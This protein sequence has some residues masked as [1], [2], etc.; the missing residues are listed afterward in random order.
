MLNKT[1]PTNIPTLS[2][3][4]CLDN[5]WKTLSECLVALEQSK[6]EYAVLVLQPTVEAFFLIHAFN[7]K[8]AASTT[9][10][11]AEEPKTE[12][13]KFVIKLLMRLVEI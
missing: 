6:D 5:L 10:K 7:K 11:P 2:Q 12:P 9:N 8:P 1:E 13:G 3:I 4:L